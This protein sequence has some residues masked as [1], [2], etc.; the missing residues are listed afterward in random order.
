MKTNKRNYLF[1]LT[2]LVGALIWV[3]PKPVEV[4][5]HAWHLFAIFISTILG[6]ILK[7]FPMGAMALLGL[8]ATILTKTLSFQDAFSGF[9]NSVV[10]LVVLAFFIAKGFINTGLGK[11]VAY[12]FV[13]KLGKNALGLSY[14][15]LAT[16]F[17]LSPAIPSLTARVGG[18]IYPMVKGL[19]ET[20]KSKPNHES[21][22]YIGAF[23]IQV[24][25]QGSAVTAAMFLTS[26]AANP[27]IA[28]MANELGIKISWGTWALGSIVP[29][30]ISL[31]SIPLILYKLYPPT[32]KGPLQA[33][34][35][36]KKQLESLGK[37]K[38]NEWIMTT[39]F[40]LLIT[41]WILGPYI[42]IKAA[43]VALIGLAFLLLTD[44][45]TWED[46]LEEKKAWDTLIW[47]STLVTLAS[48]LNKFGLIS[49]FSGSITQYVSGLNWVLG[50]SILALIYFY[51]HYFFASALAHVGAMYAPFLAV[52][53]ALGAPPIVAALILGYLSSLFGTLTQFS[54]GPA[55]ILYG[56]GYV[57]IGAWWKLGFII[58]LVNLFIWLIIGGAWW[59]FIGF[60]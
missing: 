29:G 13:S 57:T 36:S 59:K 33:K 38:T 31:I 52:A 47:F 9:S 10:W 6:V 35:F 37:M 32:L 28:E 56:S 14:G 22:R 50:F 48:F 40:L 15:V 42:Q 19:A 54:S 27:L 39:T 11:R 49:W 2:V 44:V 21:S 3:V 26:M 41:L 7:P 55:P 17:L 60:W 8:T 20:F 53:I 43:T 25:F 24:V 4:E 46:I 23:L 30:M 34:A 51:S 12:F 58:S 1:L 16:D 5:A 45:F 18:I